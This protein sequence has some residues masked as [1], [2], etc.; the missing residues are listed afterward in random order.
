MG[1]LDRR[2]LVSPGGR[3]SRRFDA[4]SSLRPL[5]GRNAFR[6]P[7]IMGGLARDSSFGDHRDFVARFPTAARGRRLSPVRHFTG[8]PVEFLSPLRGSGTGRK[9][10]PREGRGWEGESVVIEPQPL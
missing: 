2:R 7:V 5:V 4:C 1:Y 3:M 8:C 9:G 6:C 10:F